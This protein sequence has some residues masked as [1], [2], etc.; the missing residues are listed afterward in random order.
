MIDANPNRPKKEMWSERKEGPLITLHQVRDE[1][2]E[3]EEAIRA[4]QTER[5]AGRSLNDQVILYRTNA[6]SRLFEE[7]CLRAGLP[8]RLIG[9]VKFYARREVKDVLAYLHVI[10]NPNDTVSLLRIINVPARK[11]GATSMQHI[12][13]FA[14]RENLTLWQTLLRI[15]EVV[16]LNSGLRDRIYAFTDLLK[17]KQEQAN[18]V[19]V[20]ELTQGL[21]SEIEF[22]KWLR[23]DS[24]E[25]EERWNN[26][27]EL[28]TV[29]KKYDQ[30]DPQTSLMSFLEEVAL[31]SE[32]DKLATAQDDAVTLMTL[33]LC[34]GLEYEHVLIAGCEE[35]LFPH[36][37]TQFDKEQ[38]EEERRLMYV[39]MTR[40]KTKLH[41]LYART[42]N[43]WGNE[44][45]NAPSRF[46]DDLPEAMLERRSDELLS[47]FAWASERGVQQVRRSSGPLQPFRQPHSE[48]QSEFNQ[49]I[50]FDDANQEQ[51][52]F[53][54][55]ARVAHPAFGA[56]TITS[57]RGD[58][59]SIS[60]DNG[61][62]KT[63]ALNIAPL[64]LL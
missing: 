24:D 26:V 1:R 38:L 45:A 13:N 8:Y 43:Q 15:D 51:S 64:K 50:T 5:A 60:F 10:T 57:R 19:V 48:A 20:S 33:H 61:Q 49:D 54:E 53:F 18:I 17:R 40:A 46:L 12:Q 37:N 58:L 47:A 35:G 2:K 22:E 39:G 7:A 3:A 30:L 34:K 56:G 27:Q 11:I 6:Q 4:I 52:E 41:I 36:S 28:F 59:V 32:V 16:E 63:F 25:G 23:D 21:L 42:R 62:K 14:A 31:V 9:G 44:Q 55:G 29:M